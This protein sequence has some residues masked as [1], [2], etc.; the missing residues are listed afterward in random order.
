MSGTV[1]STWHILRGFNPYN[2]FMIY[3]YYYYPHFKGEEMRHTN[4]K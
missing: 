2:I 1:L 3:I 4:I